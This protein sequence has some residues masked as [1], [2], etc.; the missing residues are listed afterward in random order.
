VILISIVCAVVL[1]ALVG[2]VVRRKKMT[3]ETINEGKD[4]EK[5]KPQLQ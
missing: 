3:F 1:H 2:L 4:K 5:P